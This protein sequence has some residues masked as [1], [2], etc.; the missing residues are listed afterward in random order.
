LLAGRVL[1]V[2][3]MVNGADFVETF[4]ELVE[5]YSFDEETAYMMTMRVHRGG[6]FAKD[7]VYLGGLINVLD[8]VA[9]RGDL[10][11]LFV[12]KIATRH[13]PI[14]QELRRRGVLQP[15]PLQPYYLS[16]PMAQ[17]RLSKLR[18]KHTSVFDLV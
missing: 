7:A 15:P 6:G 17:E 4:R 10:Q 12:G 5:N 11:P 16:M 18:H 14:I 2:K 1:A 3:M 13:I 9:H 8:Y